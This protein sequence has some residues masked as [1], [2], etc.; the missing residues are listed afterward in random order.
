[1][2]M[3]TGWVD[4]NACVEHALPSHAGR[5]GFESLMWTAT[6]L[7]VRLVFIEVETPEG[8]RFVRIDK[9]QQRRRRRP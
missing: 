7:Q 9:L 2:A 6:I 1:M 4:V 8:K 5:N 3:A